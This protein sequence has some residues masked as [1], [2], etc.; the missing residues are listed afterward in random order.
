VFVFFVDMFRVFERFSMVFGLFLLRSGVCD[1]LWICS[2]YVFLWISFVFLLCFQWFF[3]IW[4]CSGVCDVLLICSVFVFFVDMFPVCFCARFS[5]ELLCFGVCGDLWIC[6]VSVFFC[7]SIFSGLLLVFCCVLFGVC[8]V[9]WIC[10]VFVFVVD[11]CCVLVCC[12]VLFCEFC[13]VLLSSVEL[14]W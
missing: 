14:C 13:C 4:L 12:V 10:S 8:D 5:M 9:L 6:S 7:G 11:F 2:V 3:A 1:V